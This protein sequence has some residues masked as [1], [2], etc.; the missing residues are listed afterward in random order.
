MTEQTAP[1]APARPSRLRRTALMLSV[2]VLIAAGAGAWWLTS[3]GSESTENAY[4][5]QAR[6]SVAAELGGRVVE[7]AVSDNQRVKAGDLLF[8]IDPE[9]YRITLAKAEAALDAARLD[10]QR[11]KAAYAEAVAQ[12]KLAHD[13][14]EYQATNLQRQKAL[15]AKGVATDSALDDALHAARMA[16]EQAAAADISVQ[17]ALAAL[18]GMPDGAVDDHPE[19]RSALVAREA[20]AYDLK[21]TEVRAPADGVIYQASS[22]RTG[23]MVSTGSTLFTLVETGEVWVEANFKETQLSDIRVGQSAEV[24]LDLAR[25]QRLSGHVEAIGAGTGAE[26]SLLPAQNATGNWVKVEQR[27]PVRIALDD[28]SAAPLLATGLS[29]AVE[30]RTSAPGGSAQAGTVAP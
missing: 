22:F 15:T 29:A 11:L 4:V 20:A 1:V 24:V 12:A 23:Q 17:A 10:V 27:V 16:A 7:V 18:G 25:G 5:H 21:R 26:F 6:L 2:P 13:T 19:V 8:R 14:A 9:P 3:G 28:P 30:V